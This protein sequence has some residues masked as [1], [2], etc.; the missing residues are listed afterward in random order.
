MNPEFQRYLWLELPPH[1]LVA[2]PA[3]LLLIFLASWLAGGRDAIAPAS[4][5]T[6]A[7]LLMVWGSRLAADSVLSEVTA[8]TW[9]NQRMSSIGPWDMTWGKL[10]GSTVYVWY[11]AFWCLAAYAFAG[12]GKP[13]DVIRLLLAGLQAQSLALLFS[14]L[15]LRRGAESLQVYVTVA[16]VAAILLVL[17]VQALITVNPS[18]FV[19]WYG[20]T[21]A[22]PVFLVSTQIAFIAWTILGIYRLMLSE[23]QFRAG[24]TAWFAFI[25]FVAL[26]L[27]GFDGLL[28]LAGERQLP[29]MLVT[30]FFIAFAVTVVMTY[31]AAFVEPKS[32]VRLRRW[33]Q[34]AQTGKIDRV[35]EMIP[36]WVISSVIAVML[37]LGTLAAIMLGASDW[38][39]MIWSIG[40]FIIAMMLFAARD[41]AMLYYLVLHERSRR[42]HL[43]TVVYLLI[44]WFLAPVALSAANL[45]ELTPIFVPSQSGPA[46]LV[47]LPVLAQAVIAVMLA[48]RRWH[49]VR[50][51]DMDRPGFA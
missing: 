27:A 47:V 24:Q 43:T 15:L 33:V 19:S 30:R 14:L 44:L 3:V 41:I 26:F 42:A 1:R 11:G 37:A 9:D 10:V 5:I 46:A 16:Q 48:L 28:V 36:I 32:L 4:Q 6:L 7:L 39:M 13:V 51:A 38:R 2:M 34:F 18:G 31:V 29:G 40:P 49:A 21:V 12:S 20:L 35:I 8:R 23:L 50:S 17:P 25:L 22:E 45:E